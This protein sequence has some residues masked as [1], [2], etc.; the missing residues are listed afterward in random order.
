MVYHFTTDDVENCRIRDTGSFN[1]NDV[2]IFDNKTAYLVIRNEQTRPHVCS[3][4]DF[5]RGYF[6]GRCSQVFNCHGG[7]LIVMEVDL[8]THKPVDYTTVPFYNKE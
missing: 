1:L 3:R 6:R 4:C 2:I 8:I 7:D 5:G